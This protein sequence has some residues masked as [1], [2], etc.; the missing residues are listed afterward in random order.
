MLAALALGP[1]VAQ[2]RSVPPGW[3]GVTADGPLLDGRA[4]LDAELALMRSS[5]VET[6]RVAVYWSA[7]QPLRPGSRRP[8]GW[9]SIGG[10]PT[11]WD[12]IDHVMAALGAHGLRVLP[13]VLQAP[14]WARLRRGQEWS[15]PTP[16]AYARYGA[17]LT[18]LVRRY[19]PAGR[20]W[21]SRPR[22]ARAP[23]RDWQVWNEPN[24]GR[25]WTVQPGMPSYTRL[26]KVAH[27]AIHAGHPR[28]R[29]VLAG[30]VGLSYRALEEVYRRGGRRSFDVAAIHPFTRRLDDVILLVRRAR[31]V[32]RAHG[33]ARKPLDLTEISWTSARG[34]ATTSFGYDE[35][36]AGQARRVSAALT[37]LAKVRRRYGLERVLWYTWLS[38]EREKSYP[39]DWSGLR[40]LTVRGVRSKPALRAFAT[41]AR[42]LER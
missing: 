8:V 35:T 32:M 2:A 4:N 28:A 21:A 12:A 17:F 39:F 15:P 40:A 16:R 23:V 18:A 22:A 9:G 42:R 24:G 30:L 3:T 29:T 20:F 27:R 5:G 11:R 25:F 14:V 34:K 1:T 26:L 10:V 33:D 13:V 36:E 31:E 7:T 41:A 6:A 38:M 19:G 37:T